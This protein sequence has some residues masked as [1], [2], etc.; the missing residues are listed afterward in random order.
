[1]IS[2]PENLNKKLKCDCVQFV[3]TQVRIRLP[4]LALKPGGDVTRS[5]K[6]GI[7]GPTKRTYVLKKF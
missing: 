5:P 4:I 2:S 3:I 6:K 1:M 7:N